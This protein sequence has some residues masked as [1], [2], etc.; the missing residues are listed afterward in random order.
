MS[1]PTGAM[2]GEEAFH[3]AAGRF[4]S[5]ARRFRGGACMTG[6]P[7]MVAADM[8]DGL[9]FDAI[10]AHCVLSRWASEREELNLTRLADNRL[11][12]KRDH[13]AQIIDE[14]DAF[15]LIIPP[16]VA[17]AWD[18]Q[19]AEVRRVE[20]EH[21][22]A[23]RHP[24]PNYGDHAWAGPW[25]LLP[26]TSYPPDGVPIVYFLYDASDTLA[27]VGSSGYFR[28]RM[29]AHQNTKSWVRWTARDCA[30]RYDAYQREWWE[31]H[32]NRPYLNALD[33]YAA[34]EVAERD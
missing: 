5:P 22:A 12:G 30:T 23:E 2:P 17:E 19:A 34:Q 6:R 33:G 16:E 11:G 31:I 28:A 9:S 10:G 20:R 3:W 15:G 27:Y 25:P 24:L 32:N 18:R 4:P 21:R 14:L 8:V 13:A 7:A 1:T 26:A 29:N